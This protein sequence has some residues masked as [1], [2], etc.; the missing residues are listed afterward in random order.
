MN[1]WTFVKTYLSY[2]LSASLPSGRLAFFYSII[3][4]CPINL[5]Q[6]T[7]DLGYKF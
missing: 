6:R 7:L 1:K 2:N 3:L 5:S 4:V